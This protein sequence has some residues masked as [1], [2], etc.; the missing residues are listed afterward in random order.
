MCL[1]EK[2]KEELGKMQKIIKTRKA[3]CTDRSAE[4]NKYWG[5]QWA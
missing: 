5:I 3:T 4:D 2:E 1:W